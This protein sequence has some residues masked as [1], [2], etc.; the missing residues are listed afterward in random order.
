[1]FSKYKIS[2]SISNICYKYNRRP[3]DSCLKEDVPLAKIVAYEIFWEPILKI[4]AFLYVDQFTTLRYIVF[5][6]ERGSDKIVI[7]I[8]VPARH[9]KLGDRNVANDTFQGPI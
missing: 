7:F 1:M 4:I 8:R 9:E 3:Q 6:S 5:Q 2:R